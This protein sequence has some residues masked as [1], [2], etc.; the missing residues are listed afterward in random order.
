ML[1]VK[2]LP[3]SVP[4]SSNTYLLTSSGESAVIDPSSAFDPS[5]VTGLLKYIILTHGHYDHMINIDEWAEKTDARVLI[6]SHDK[7]KLSD[8]ALNCASLFAVYDGRY[9]GEVSCV[10]DGDIIELSDERI[11][12][13]ST[14]GHT[15]GSVSLLCGDKIFVGDTIFAGGGYGKCCFPGGDFS[16]IKK[17]IF[18]LTELA[19]H[20]KVCPGHG[21]ETTIGEY[22]KD[23][24]R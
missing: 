2:L 21:P 9:S 3:P 8:P 10:A 1:D 23:I 13:I 11:Q 19:D 24:Y 7:D 16:E 15:P 12:V 6:S 18:R 17:S 4:Y 14:P 20:I 22:K 5:C